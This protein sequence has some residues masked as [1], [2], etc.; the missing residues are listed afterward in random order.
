MLDTETA[1]SLD[2]PLCYDIGFAVIDEDGTIYDEKNFVVADVY[3]NKELMSSA[4][5]AEKLPQYEEELEKGIR[6]MAKLSTI[7]KELAKIMREHNT[8]IVVA[9]NARFDY[10]STNKTQRY[11]TKSANRY[12]FPYGTEIWDTLKMAREVLKTDKEY[13]NF[14]YENGYL[15]KRGCRRY[16]AEILYR[17]FSGDN[18]FVEKHTGLEDVYIEKVI[19]SECMKR[20]AESGRLW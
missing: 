19:F 13:E 12:F 8:N 15:T 9:H 17:F 11:I 16:T 7:R 14:C 20:G 6:T 3:L 2:D 10:R 5:Y 1:N 4:Y 18:E